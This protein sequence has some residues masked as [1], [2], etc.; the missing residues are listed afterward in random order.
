MNGIAR[1][2]DQQ[3]NSRTLEHTH[4]NAIHFVVVGSGKLHT[5]INL[6][7]CRMIMTR[8]VYN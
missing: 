6:R 2:Y 4:T 8:D 3:K 7:V 1:E 5:Y